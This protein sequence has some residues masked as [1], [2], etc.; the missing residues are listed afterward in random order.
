VDITSARLSLIVSS[1]SDEARPAAD[2][3]EKFNPPA[4]VK[5][6]IAH[7]VHVGG[8]QVD[9]PGFNDANS[10]IENWVNQICPS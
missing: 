5:D 3:L 7:L 1:T 2:T 4:N 6:A 10:A 9:D 8:A